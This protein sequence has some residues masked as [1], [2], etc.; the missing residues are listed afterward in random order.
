MV[1]VNDLLRGLRFGTAGFHSTTNFFRIEFT[2][3]DSK[4]PLYLEIQADSLPWGQST[5]APLT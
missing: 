2:Y 4:V 5:A 3:L 1:D